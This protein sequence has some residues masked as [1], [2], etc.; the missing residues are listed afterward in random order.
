MTREFR[1]IAGHTPAGLRAALS[2]RSPGFW[3]F[4]PVRVGFV[5]DGS[6]PDA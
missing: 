1:A 5:Q 2:E 6:H 3:A 4:R